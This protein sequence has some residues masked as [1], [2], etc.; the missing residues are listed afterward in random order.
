MTFIAQRR[1]ILVHGDKKLVTFDIGTGK[2]NDPKTYT[3][4]FLG[5]V[6]FGKLTYNLPLILFSFA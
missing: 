3:F 2:G 6:F 5:K 1:D 4:Y